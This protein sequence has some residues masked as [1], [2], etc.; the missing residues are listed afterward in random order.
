MYGFDPFRRPE[1]AQTFASGDIG[2]L[3]ADRL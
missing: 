3:S 2:P 1:F